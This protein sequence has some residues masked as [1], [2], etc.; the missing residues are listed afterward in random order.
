M[1]QKKTAPAT[2]PNA[3]A[4]PNAP[5]AAAKTRKRKSVSLKG[6]PTIPWTSARNAALVSLLVT[7]NGQLTTAD[8]LRT[9]A[10]DPSFAGSEHLLS[11]EGAKERLKQQITKLSKRAEK[12][13]HTKLS[14]LRTNQ[15]GEELDAM[16]DA[17]FK[18]AQGKAA[19]APMPLPH[20]VGVGA[21]VL[22]VT[23]PQ[24]QP[25]STGGLIPV[26]P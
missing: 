8:I 7:H 14:L 25:V 4:D 9:L 5:A 24:P 12:R 10:A 19:P 3:V 17:A 6:L 23:E 16:L 11:Q 22:T 18:Q 2:D 26:T 20:N 1:A 13:G 15:Q 21:P